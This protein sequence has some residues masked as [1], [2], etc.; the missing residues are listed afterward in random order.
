MAQKN[1]TIRDIAKKAGVSPAL[2]SFVMNNRVEAN[3]KKRYRVSE[4]SRERIL[5]VAAEMNYQ[6]NAAARML[7]HGRSRVIG[8]ILSDMANLFYGIIARELENVAAEYGYTVLF[9]S[10]DENPGKFEQL[11]HSFIDKDVEGFI[12]VPCAGS[13]PTMEYLRSTRYP[14]VVIDR[15]HPDFQVP[16]V[17]MDNHAAMDEAVRI[18]TG[19][20]CRKIELVTYAMR[21]SSMMDREERFVQILRDRGTAEED[22]C[23]YRLPFDRVSEETESAIDQVIAHG[24]DGLILAS[25]VLSAAVI[26]ALFRRKIRIQQDIRIVGFDYSNLYDVFDPPIPFI[27]QP[28]GEISRQAAEYLMQIIETKRKDGDISK[29]TDKII[30]QGRVIRGPV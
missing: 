9:G 6:P 30:L 27:M 19:Q 18:L 23:I 10:S 3:G 20:G 26:K 25:N 1:I 2:V 13:A 22:I 28:L 4:A 29:I 21:I 5:S 14:F 17:L 12:I 7:R 15:H 16:S 8:A 24:A 11:V